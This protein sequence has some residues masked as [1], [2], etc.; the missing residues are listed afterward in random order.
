MRGVL[1]I[2]HRRQL[3]NVSDKRIRIIDPGESGELFGNSA[4]PPRLGDVEPSATLRF[5]CERLL[6]ADGRQGLDFVHAE[7]SLLG[8]EARRVLNA[9]GQEDRTRWAHSICAVRELFAGR[10]EDM[11]DN[12]VATF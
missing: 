7:G 10:N 9:L 6:L 4:A 11:V 8:V 5:A 3:T 12:L 2:E 1:H